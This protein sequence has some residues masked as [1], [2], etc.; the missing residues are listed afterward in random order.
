MEWTQ[1]KGNVVRATAP[2]PP[3]D[4]DPSHDVSLSTVRCTRETRAQRMQ[5][6]P[7]HAI[8]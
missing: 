8:T 5:P 1:C 4:T 2:R 7:N 3:T 6:P